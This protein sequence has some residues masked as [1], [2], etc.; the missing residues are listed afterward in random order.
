METALAERPADDAAAAELTP[1]SQ[2]RMVLAL[3]RA[4]QAEGVPCTLHE[5]H[6]SYVLVSPGGTCK[7][8]KAVALGF[9]DFSTRARR[10]AYCRAEV[11]LNGRLAPRL[12]RGVL[13]VTGT[14]DAPRWGG[15]G[16]PID[17]AVDLETFDDRQQW[18]RL[19]Q[20]GA[21][22][23]S[24]IDR[25]A[26]R[27]AEF[28][29]DAEAAGAERRQ[30]LPPQVREPMQ[31]NLRALAGLL[32]DAAE[33]RIV[34]ELG[35]WEAAAYVR[36]AP[37]FAR[38]RAEGRVREGHGDLHLGNIVQID[39]EPVA[40]DC[41]EFNDDFRW[42]D[43]MSDIAFLAMDLAAAGQPALA[44]RFVNAYFDASG[45]HD[46]A[47]V[48]DY[49]LVHRALVRAKVAALRCRQE[50]ADTGHAEPG[51]RAVV[52]DDL[53]LAA[54]F[55]RPRHPALI[56]THGPSG[57]GK[58][59]HTQPLLEAL[60]AVRIRADVERKRL[61]GL[62]PLQPSGS[63]LGG[64]LYGPEATQATYRQAC[65][66]AAAVIEGGR[67]AI[68][69]AAFLRGWQRQLARGVAARLRVPFVILDFDADP[70]V[71]RDRVQRRHAM[72]D[73]ASEATLAVLE[74]QLREAEPLDE[75]ERGL[76]L[77]APHDAGS[78]EMTRLQLE[79]L[80]RSAPAEEEPELD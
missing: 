39:G 1:D 72:G 42:I 6:I 65:R 40:F 2:R 30:G 57:S 27:L 16:P 28:H 45:D 52:H 56:I 51:E 49:Y 78:I 67:D 74:S 14:P 20:R 55:I 54:A 60:G 32:D 79:L 29:R 73:D 18:D 37:V 63:P 8:K 64:G 80:R 25:L 12:Y 10:L 46:G 61:H 23:P 19:A 4:R 11:R 5:T 26:A 3:Q 44:H 13:N 35:A 58:T 21:L 75:A 68:I 24:S 66:A 7:F 77:A 41:I 34:L 47:R 62:A 9:V 53:A 71:L 59:T 38:R 33:R 36:L 22:S 50:L 17:H 69:D 15:D 43:V 76:T 48:L 70:G 31:D